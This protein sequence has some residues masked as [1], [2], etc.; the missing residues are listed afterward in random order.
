MLLNEVA[1][2]WRGLGPVSIRF[3]PGQIVW[4]CGP[5]GGGKSTLCALISGRLEPSSGCFIRGDARVGSVC[6]DVEGQLLGATVAQELSLGDKN[7]RPFGTTRF[8]GLASGLMRRWVGLEDVDPQRLAPASQQLLLLTCLVQSACTFLIVDE[9]L[10]GLDQATFGEVCEVLRSISRAGAVVLVVSHEIR[11]LP[12][13]DRMLV[14]AAGQVVADR[15]AKEIT[16]KDLELARLWQGT[17]SAAGCEER[18]EVIGFQREAVE[19]LRHSQLGGVFL[20]AGELLALAGS[21]DSGVYELPRLIAGG[22]GELAGGDWQSFAEGY[23]VLLPSSARSLLWRGS[24][25]AELKASLGEGRRRRPDLAQRQKE[26]VE[27]PSEWLE[28]LPRTLSYGQ[29]KFLAFFCLLLQWPDLLICQ[30][31]FAGLDKDLRRLAEVK[32]AEYLQAGG[33]LVM[34]THCSQEMLYYANKLLVVEDRA[35]VYYGSSSDY[36]SRGPR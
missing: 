24:V 4:L 29:S 34:T 27:I 32:L 28:S 2:S 11:M 35:P 18:D 22:Q 8:E 21:L 14:L 19:V 16:P 15:L 33:I 23:R 12:W 13:A 25:R 17:G 9:A 5:S 20:E 31:P 26:V 30:H 3:E 7:K 36:F 1:Y 10:F 6:A